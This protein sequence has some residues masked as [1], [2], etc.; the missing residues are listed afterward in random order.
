MAATADESYPNLRQILEDQLV[1]PLNRIPG[2]GAVNIQG[3]PV[4]EIQVSVDPQRLAAYGVTINQIGQALSNE[5]VVIPA[6]ELEVGEQQYN[7]RIDTEFTTVGEIGQIIVKNT[8]EGGVVRI[9]D[10]A[11]VRDAID[12]ENRIEVVNSERAVTLAVQ[13]QNNANTVQ[14]AEAVLARIPA[15]SKSLPPDV[16]IATVVD[17]SDFIINSID[18]LSEVLIYAVIFV[19][20]VVFIFLRRWRATF[21]IAL[22]IPVSLIAAFIYLSITGNTLNL[23]LLSS[24]SI[25]L[26]MVVDDAIV[27]LENIATYVDRGTNPREAALYGT[28]EVG[29]A[30]IA[31]TLTVVAVFL[32]L[33]FL[34]GLTGIWFGQLGSIVVVT[35]VVSTL[36]AL[37]LIPMMSSQLLKV[38]RSF[39]DKSKSGKSLRHKLNRRV[40]GALSS[41]GNGYK[42]LLGWSLNHKLI[43]TAIA[44]AMFV[45]SL[46]LV[47]RVGTEFMPQSD[48]GR[49]MVTIELPTG[50]SPE[51]AL[52]TINKVEQIFFEKVPELRVI[53]SGIG[54]STGGGSALGSAST[55]PNTLDVTASLVP[56]SERERSVFEIAE[57]VRAELADIPE[58][59]QYSVSTQGGA[60]AGPPVAINIVGNNMEQTS[61]IAAQLIEKLQ[62]I[63][64]VRNADE[65]RGDPQPAL[66]IE[67]DR[68]RLA[69]LGLNSGVV[70]QSIRNMIAGLTA[71]EF[72]EEGEEFDIVVQYQDVFRQN[73]DDIRRMAVATP[74]GELVEVG[75]LGE[76]EEIYTPPKIERIGRER[77]IQVTADLFETPLNVVIEE[78]NDFIANELDVPPG[79]EIAFAGDIEEQ[80]DAFEDLFLL[81]GLS[82]ILVYIVM[83]AQFESLKD[84]FIIMFSLPF[85]FTG[86]L[87]ALVVTNTKLS[88]IAFIGGI[89]LVGIVVK[90]AIVLVDF[91]Q[92]LRGR[93]LSLFDAIVESGASRLRPVLMTTLT[94]LL[95]M[96]PLAV[97]QGEGSET[98]K[99]MAVAVIGGLT[100]STLITL[101]LVPVLYAFFHRKRKHKVSLLTG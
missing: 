45:G 4:R 88:V 82:I 23:I 53:S 66:E 16:E 46:L 9:G 6:G 37:T 36:A 32:P 31:T 17:T 21:I 67:L 95:A 44:F 78:V 93:G 60:G 76:V 80:Q 38:Q 2:V 12:E 83:A 94:T 55:G 43:V 75:S 35:I 59:I 51:S 85:A 52:A 73:I 14:V 50:R 34:T 22:T 26:G 64:G 20:L 8:S 99:P 28:N 19:V 47:P 30:V 18:N 27:V 62:Q 74:N 101:V 79:V 56:V 39:H 97:S 10:V 61:E 24:L 70:G 100:F 54:S 84:P 33:T 58:A 3:G 69:A 15:L 68:D 1:T 86:V 89:I 98:W 5:N 25:A 13:K 40:E 92:L 87:L 77:S 48:N 49:L 63:E 41:L 90:N 7:V 96:F 91:I 81:L 72:R 42:K 65:S 71:T 57:V 29:V 11:V